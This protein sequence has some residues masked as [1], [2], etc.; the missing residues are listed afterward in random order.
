[1]DKL[2]NEAIFKV[3]SPTSLFPKNSKKTQI[4]GF[5]EE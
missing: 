1:M 2:D 4:V 3:H 5:T